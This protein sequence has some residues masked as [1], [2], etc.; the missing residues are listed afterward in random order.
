MQGMP[1][2][3]SQICSACGSPLDAPI[4]GGKIRCAFCGT[5]NLVEA[6]EM[7]RGDEVIC[8]ECGAANP[9]NAQ[10]CGR[11]GIKLEF[12]CPNCNALNSYGTVYCLQCGVDIQAEIKRRQAQIKS[13]QAEEL[14]RQEEIRQQIAKDKRKKKISRL[15]TTGLMS[16]FVLCLAIVG[17][18]W[19][20]TNEFS[21]AALSTKTAISF[22]ETATEKYLIL[23][24]DNFSDP[25]SGWDNST[26]TNGSSRYDEGGYRITINTNKWIIWDTLPDV[27]QND[28]R[29]EVDA[30]KLG[31]PDSNGFGVLCRY[32][33][34][35]NFYLF[36]IASTGYAEIGRMLNGNFQIISS[37]DN[38]W[39]KSPAIKTGSETN[40]IR[41]DCIGTSLTMYVNGSQVVTTTD[42]SFS[43]GMVG[44]SSAA[45]DTGGT[46]ILFN[47][48]FVYRP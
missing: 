37:T 45:Y 18:G 32:Q 30:T 13:Q 41:A 23:F 44:L 10:H 25:K 14:H 43:G 9:Q 21:P 2:T 35:K 34:D 38:T 27:F 7:K 33:D 42:S 12:N 46:D 17:G 29:I 47:N 16:I 24:Q 11:C 15:V 22:Q 4:Q 48:F 3:I 6:Q 20:Y 8:P 19:L 39:V 36:S 1:K 5:V 28:I 31:G 40:H 26:I